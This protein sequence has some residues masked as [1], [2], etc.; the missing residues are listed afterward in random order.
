MGSDWIGAT[1]AYFGFSISLVDLVRGTRWHQ[2][3]SL[4]PEDDDLDD[5][6]R[7]PAR[8]L[9]RHW[10][11]HGDPRVQV[12]LGPTAMPCLYETFVAANHCRVVFGYPLPAPTLQPSSTHPDCVDCSYSF[13]FP[14]DMPTRIDAFLASFRE[15]YAMDCLPPRA[16]F[17]RGDLSPHPHLTFFVG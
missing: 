11:D 2:I 1:D 13:P 12:F 6:E 15:R 3:D 7:H 14:T 10:A 4:F 16:A 8:A 17:P 5:P 9:R